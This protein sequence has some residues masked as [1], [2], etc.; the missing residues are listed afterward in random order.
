MVILALLMIA[1]IAVLFNV[2][3]SYHSFE[4][5]MGTKMAQVAIAYHIVLLLGMVAVGIGLGRWIDRMVSARKFIFRSAQKGS[6]TE[7]LMNLWGHELKVE[8]DALP[9]LEHAPQ[10]EPA[11]IEP[12]SLFDMPA[13]RGRKPA[14][15]LDRWLPIAAKWENRDTTRD[16]FTLGELIAEHLGTNA[17]GS[18]IVSEQAYYS[19]W[20]P[21]AIEELRRRGNAKK[22][23]TGREPK[24]GL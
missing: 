20:R 15:T 7:A 19:T 4:S 10:P 8:E 13:R 11:I 6:W 3:W 17:D 24:P 18:P 21:R 14:F 1:A 23:M 16:A 12:L 2:A 5:G 22:R 9:A